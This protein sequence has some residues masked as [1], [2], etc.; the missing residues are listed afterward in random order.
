MTPNSPPSA[1]RYRREVELGLVRDPLERSE[2]GHALQNFGQ[3][4]YDLRTPDATF[5]QRHEL[6]EAHGYLLLAGEASKGFD[7]IFIEATQQNTIH[8]DGA[9]ACAA[10][11]AESREHR[12]VAAFDASNAGEAFGL[13]GVHADGDPVQASLLEWLDHLGQQVA[14]GGESQFGA[15]HRWACAG[16]KLCGRVAQC[17]DA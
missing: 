2:A 10:R 9:E 12:R 15:V 17:R 8:L 7:L 16:R 1:K 14:V 5:F 6:D 4:D 3:R 13:D 11:G